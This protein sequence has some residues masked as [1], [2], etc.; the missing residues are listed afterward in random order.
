M[1]KLFK[2]KKD[3]N[4]ENPFD[5]SALIFRLLGLFFRL[6]NCFFSSPSFPLFMA[7]FMSQL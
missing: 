6:T 4:E 5:L 3:E 2:E 7:A 1:K